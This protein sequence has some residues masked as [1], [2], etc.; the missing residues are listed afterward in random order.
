MFLIIKKNLEHFIIILVAFYAYLTG[1]SFESILNWM[2]LLTSDSGFCQRSAKEV[3]HRRE[4]ICN[5][6]DAC[7]LK[8]SAWAREINLFAKLEKVIFHLIRTIFCNLKADYIRIVSP[9]IFIR[10]YKNCTI[11]ITQQLFRILETSN[12]ELLLIIF[13]GWSFS[14]IVT[15]SQKFGVTRVLDRAL[16][17]IMQKLQYFCANV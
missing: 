13:N 7:V 4:I 10:N 5:L 6:T 3:K 9:K 15:K 1:F 2:R 14:T 16:K 12:M 8:W 11:N 17:L